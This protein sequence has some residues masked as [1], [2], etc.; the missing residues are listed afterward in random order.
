MSPILLGA[1]ILVGLTY[2]LAIAYAFGHDR[3]YDKGYRDAR[4]IPIGHLK[5]LSYGKDGDAVMLAEFDKD[6]TIVPDPDIPGEH[7]G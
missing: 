6:V 5:Q 1:F 4:V 2:A 3:G 7:L